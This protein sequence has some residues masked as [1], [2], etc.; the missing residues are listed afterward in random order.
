MNRNYK[1]GDVVKIK[2]NAILLNLN[3]RARIVRI[4]H[5]DGFSKMDLEP[6][7]D[8]RDIN[9][10]VWHESLFKGYI[11]NNHIHCAW[12]LDHNYNI[13]KAIT[14]VLDEP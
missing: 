10:H 12:E 9:G 14:E 3:K 6:L 8:F 5:E 7:G 1:V 4:F 2:K 13:E 11:N